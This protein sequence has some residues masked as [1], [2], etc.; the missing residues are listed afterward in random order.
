MPEPKTLKMTLPEGWHDLSLEDRL[1]S[2]L[3]TVGIPVS[4][5]QITKAIEEIK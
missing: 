2:L 1:R 4:N 3:E 5:T